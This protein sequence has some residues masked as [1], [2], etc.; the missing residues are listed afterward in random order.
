MNLLIEWRLAKNADC[1]YFI[2]IQLLKRERNVVRI[3]GGDFEV[4]HFRITRHER[5]ERVWTVAERV[6]MYPFGDEQASGYTWGRIKGAA[7][8]FLIWPTLLPER[9]KFPLKQRFKNSL[10][11]PQ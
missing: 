2:P 10:R 6:L 9:L 1:I 3:K 7:R 8:C 4:M 5:K 11:A